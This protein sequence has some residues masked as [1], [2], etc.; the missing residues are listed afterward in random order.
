M[1]ARAQRWRLSSCAQHA[2][3]STRIPPIGAFTRSRSA[4]RFVGRG[5]R[6]T[7]R[8]EAR[9]KRPIHCVILRQLWRGTDWGVEGDSSAAITSPVT[10]RS[11]AAVAELRKRKHRDEK[12]FCDHGPRHGSRRVSVR[13]ID[14]RA[15]PVAVAAAPDC[16]VKKA[17]WSDHRTTPL[18]APSRLLGVMLPLHAAASSAARAR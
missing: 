9:S 2:G 14:H 4:V 18:A 10:P 1:T 17:A 6:C 15:R 16:P 7:T 11:H 13:G 3:R 12:P 5:F 8:R